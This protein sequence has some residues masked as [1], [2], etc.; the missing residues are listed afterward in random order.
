MRVNSLSDYQPVETEFAVLLSSSEQLLPL[1]KGNG[2][3]V[4]CF[5]ESELL[6]AGEARVVLI[7]ISPEFAERLIAR[8]VRDRGHVEYWAP[9]SNVTNALNLI[10]NGGKLSG[11]LAI[12]GLHVSDRWIQLRLSIADRESREVEDF[13]RGLSAPNA[14][15][16]SDSCSSDQRLESI[17]LRSILISRAATLAKPVKRF[18]PPF[19]IVALYKILERIR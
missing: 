3:V 15:K 9:R 14:E 11:S 2:T 7:D 10:G 12:S 18:V 4:F 17:S 19:A 16:A 6:K 13:I 8:L 1:P 5:S